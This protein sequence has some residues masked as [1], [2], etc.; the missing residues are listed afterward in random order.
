VNFKIQSTSADLVLSQ[1]CEMDEHFD[2][3]GAEMLITVHDS[4]VFQMPEENLHLLPAFL[5]KWVIDRVAEKYPWLPVPFLYDVEVGPSY[6]EVK[7]LEKYN[8]QVQEAG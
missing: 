4:M 1:M 7:P 6:G 2:E 5:D 3:I 8:G